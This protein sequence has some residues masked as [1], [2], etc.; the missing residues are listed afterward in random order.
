MSHLK[1]FVISLLN[2]KATNNKILFIKYYNLLAVHVISI[3]KSFYIYAKNIFSKI[4]FSE[5][6]KLIT[7]DLFKLRGKR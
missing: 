2:D 3:L 7:L 4:D 5:E 6:W 1:E